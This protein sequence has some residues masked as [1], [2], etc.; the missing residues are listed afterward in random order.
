MDK[1]LPMEALDV[2]GTWLQNIKEQTIQHL[3]HLLANE[4]PTTFPR[5]VCAEKTL[6]TFGQPGAIHQGQWMACNIYAGKMFMF[7]KQ[8]SYDEEMTIK[9]FKMSGF[10]SLFHTPV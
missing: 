3:T 2:E 5:E 4:D 8:M 6:I 10:L 1:Q 7:S 9:L